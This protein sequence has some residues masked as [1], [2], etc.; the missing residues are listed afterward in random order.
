MADDNPKGFERLTMG[1][2]VHQ[3]RIDHPDLSHRERE[4]IARKAVAASLIAEAKA[5]RDETSAYRAAHGTNI[6]GLVDQNHA[7]RAASSQLPK[8]TS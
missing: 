3:A 6:R 5:A 8:A 2:A 4:V 1:T 7:A